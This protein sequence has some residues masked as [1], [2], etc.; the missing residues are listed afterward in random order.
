MPIRE[1]DCL[2]LDQ[3]RS[4]PVGLTS[5]PTGEVLQ[6]GWAALIS[7]FAFLLQALVWDSGSLTFISFTLPHDQP[8][9]STSGFSAFN[10]Q[11]EREI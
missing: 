3:V 7:S 8:W 9:A 5:G 2:L 4:S 6:F 1:D 10:C 11:E